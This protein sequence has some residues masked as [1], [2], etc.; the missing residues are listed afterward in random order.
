MWIVI[1]I[2]ALFS[3]LTSAQSQL[4]FVLKC[5]SVTKS[6]KFQMTIHIDYDREENNIELSLDSQCNV[7]RTLTLLV[8]YQIDVMI[9]STG[10]T[11]SIV[12]ILINVTKFRSLYCH[13]IMLSTAKARYVCLLFKN[14]RNYP[15][16]QYWKY[17]WNSYPQNT[18]V[19]NLLISYERRTWLYIQTTEDCCSKMLTISRRIWRLFGILRYDILSWPPTHSC[20][21]TSGKL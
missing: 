7:I 19:K 13:P 17:N 1:W 20:W 4:I 8:S 11:G 21:Y 9:Y 2:L 15:T 16:K 6:G 18:F 10:L 12:Q 14:L 5:I 3:L